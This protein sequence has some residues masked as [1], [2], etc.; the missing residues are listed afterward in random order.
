VIPPT[1]VGDICAVKVTDVLGGCTTWRLAFRDSFA[2]TGVRVAAHYLLLLVQLWHGR[3]SAAVHLLSQPP[4][5]SN[6][7]VAPE[8]P[9]RG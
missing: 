4:H 5:F 3:L 6:P 7:P 1:V 8:A 2:R 9:K